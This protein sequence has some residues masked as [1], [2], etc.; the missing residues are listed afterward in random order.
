MTATTDQDDPAAP[1]RGGRPPLPRY[2]A[3]YAL[4][5]ELSAEDSVDAR[6]RFEALLDQLEPR[7]KVLVRARRRGA[8]EAT[9]LTLGLPTITRVATPED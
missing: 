4:Y 8:P 9:A 7:L 3:A 2:T 6:E 5:V 1:D